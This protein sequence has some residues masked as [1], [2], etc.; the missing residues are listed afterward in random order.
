MGSEAADSLHLMADAVAIV[1]VA[2]SGVVGLS[3]I[4]LNYRG[5]AIARQW[6]S[7]EERIIELRDILDSAARAL[8]HAKQ[9]ISAAHVVITQAP[10][11]EEANTEDTNIL[12]ESTGDDVILL[13]TLWNRVRIRTG[14]D[15]D[16]ALALAH[17]RKTLALL[18]TQ[19]RQEFTG[20]AS[21][22]EYREAWDTAHAAEIALYETAAK[23][24]GLRDDASLSRFGSWISRH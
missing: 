4:V 24:I 2:T 21:V 10:G 22:K 14:N 7:R 17:A 5:A 3:G 11:S 15:S 18:L 6:Q 16:L 1:S 9:R 20:Q 19:V 13:W 12:L 8:G 23:E